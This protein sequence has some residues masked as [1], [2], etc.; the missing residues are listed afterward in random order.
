MVKENICAERLLRIA[1]GITIVILLSGGMAGAAPSTGNRVWDGSKGMPTTY[2]WNSYS[3]AGFYYN[4]N[5]NLGTEQLTIRN[6]K[7]TIDEGDIQYTTSPTEVSFG[8]PGFGKY[9]VIGFMAD[10]YFAGYTKNSAVSSKEVIS[11]LGRSQLHRVLLDDDDKRIVSEGGTLTLKEGY[12]LKMKEVDIGAGPGQILV[13][14][15]K[16]GNEVDSGVVSGGNTYVYLKKVGGVSDLPIIAV[17]FDNVFRGREV[18]AAFVRGV[19]QLSEFFT[20]L[21]TGDRYGEMEISDVGLGGIDMENRNS[22]GLSPGNTVD[23][24]GDLKLTV[25]DSDVLRFALSVEKAGTFEVRGTVYPA[26]DEWTPLNF[27]LN[28][29]GTNIGFYYDMDQDIGNENLKI[30]QI[31]GSSIP[32]GKLKYSTSSREIDFG[33]SGFGKYQVIGFMADK[34]FAGFTKN[35]AI[36]S[37]EVK[38]TL[39][40]NQLHRVLLDDNI[41]RIVSQGST[42]TLKDGY[43]LKMKDIDI[44]AGQGQILIALLKDGNEVDTD[45]VSGQDTYIYSKKVGTESDLPIIAIN[46]DSVFRGREVNAAFV[47][48]IFQISESFTPVKTGDEY[49]EMEISSVDANGIK[50]ENKNSIGLSSG[51]TVDL[52]G[53]IKFKVADSGDVRFYPF[54]MVTPEMIANQLLIDAPARATAGD[55]I[56][57]KVTAG[58][59]AVE[60][61]SVGIDSDVGQTDKDGFINYTLKKTL[62]GGL[63]NLTATKLGYQKA[64]KGIE[65]TEYIESRLSID[66]PVKANQFET[67]TIRVAQNDLPVSGATA[68]FDNITIG[69]TD[70][71]GTVK[72]T[73]G[74]SGTHTIYASKSGYI[75]AA[76]D[77]DIRMPYSE[78][79]ALDINIDPEVISTG[80]TAAIISNVTN[81]GTKKDTLPVVLIINNTEV[82]SKPVTLAPGEVKEITFNQ[83]VTL[84]AGNYTVEILGQKKL[85]EVRESSPINI[86]LIL[87]IIIVV[88]AIVIY[89]MTAKK[90][91]FEVIRKHPK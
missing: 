75:T 7:R 53:N 18:N 74:E 77:I 81:T 30:G 49:G 63:Y 43:V 72:Y 41:K 69:Q 85:I 19:F 60:G 35:S 91:I 44:G 5:D 73:L 46:F 82:G 21:K 6:I 71:S 15:L 27:G 22:V 36:S 48:G 9:Q 83:E 86:F 33:Y 47:R 8:H 26:A 4:L 59:K 88:G 1:I 90:S 14:L 28:V 38:S 23:L 3:F 29:G 62:N 68:L 89:Y 66:A 13:V 64:S 42:L 2:T 17:H 54:V 11:T 80:Q 65:I 12:V 25:A 32:R 31:S 61:A 24:M 20:P 70:N 51:S 58:G 16:D 50:M 87:G 56:M 76:R 79:K 57:V 39:G 34:Y 37:K 10:K 55:A 67:I 52:M 78:Y 40:R 45:V 84:P